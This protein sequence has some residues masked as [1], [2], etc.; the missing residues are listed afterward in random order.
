[1]NLPEPRRF[2][3]RCKR[4]LPTRNRTFGLSR[5]LRRHI[6]RQRQ[7]GRRRM[8]DLQIITVVEVPV[9]GNFEGRLEIPWPG[10]RRSGVA[11][12]RAPP[13]MTRIDNAREEIADWE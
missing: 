9:V 2:E 3:G 13:W 1:M 7:A 8:V 10:L 6:H 4:L 5:S 11:D 12:R